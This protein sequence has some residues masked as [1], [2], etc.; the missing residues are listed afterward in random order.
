MFK[1]RVII[2]KYVKRVMAQCSFRTT[3]LDAKALIKI[4]CWW[5]Y[6]LYYIYGFKNIYNYVNKSRNIHIF[7]RYYG[8]S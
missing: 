3:R 1:E 4:I 2:V 6:R 7:E 5:V 8:L